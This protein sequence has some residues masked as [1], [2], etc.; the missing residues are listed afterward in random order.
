MNDS[1]VVVTWIG[2]SMQGLGSVLREQLECNL[3]QAFASEHP[4]A[5]I[6]KQRFRGFSDYPERKVILA[7]EV[8]NPDGNHSAVVKVGTE[9]EVSGDFVGWRECAVSIGVTSRLFIAPRRYDIGNDRVVIV[10]PDVYQYYFSDGRDAEPKELE[11]AVE[12]CLKRNSPTAD[13][14]ERVL[15]QV[16]SEAY[17]CFYRHAQE[18]PSQHHIRTAFHRALEVDK[19]VRVVDRWNAGELLQLRQTAAWLTGVKRMPD[20]TVRPDYIDPLDYLQWALNEPFAER[21]PSMLIGPAHGDLHGRNIIVGVARGEAEWP[22]VFDF[23]RMK[24][25]NLVAWD[26]AKLE[27][28]LKCRLL[29]LLMESEPDRKNLYSQLKID[30]GPRLPESVRLSDDDRRLQHQAERMA[31]MF[32]VEK[33]LRCWS[34]QISGHSQASRRDADFHPSIDETTP[35]GRGLRIFFRI[36]REAALALGYERPGREHKWHDEYSFALLTYGIVT[37]K[38]HAD[39][40]HA[41]WALMSAGVAA[42][43]LSQLHWPPETDAPPD[44]DAA[45]TYLQILPWAY[46]CWKSQRSSEPVSVL[47]QAILRFPYSAALKQQ[48]ALSL[49]GTGDR[50]VEQEI[51]RH[52]EPLLSQACVLRD[53]EMLSRL[54]RVFKDRGDAAYDGST[55]LADVI[56]KRL[57]TYQHYRSAF[58]YYRMAFDVTGDYYPAINAATLALLVGETELQAQLAN[59]VIDICSRLSMEG[60]DRIWLL[61]TEGEAHLLLHRTDDAAHFYNEAVCLIP[62]SETGTLQSIHNQLCR[63]HWALGANI[64][65]PVIDR[66]EKSGRLQPLEIGP[67]GNCGR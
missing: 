39:G 17:R 64:V 10:Y 20:A 52:I 4:S 54:G 27:L 60:D 15:I 19:P 57:P 59:T 56:R 37:G 34:R 50:E 18:D 29:P 61:A 58:K 65:E 36:R 22:A 5:I 41:A 62:P 51:R 7:V 1:K 31:I 28:E 66:L 43:G 47:K 40:D 46:R 25:T 44:V 53:H 14:V 45:A 8:Q 11:I 49:A 16:Y 24:Q 30:P 42:A 32:E 21:L 48:L 23:D 13:S 63:L 26:F 9:D 35:L 2:E 12:R 55:S 38:W 33:L 3:R 67:F 6:V